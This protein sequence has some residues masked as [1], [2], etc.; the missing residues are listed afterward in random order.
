MIVEFRQSDS[1]SCGHCGNES[2]RPLGVPMV[3]GPCRVGPSFHDACRLEIMSDV[4]LTLTRP[5]M[6]HGPYG[7]VTWHMV[8]MI[9]HGID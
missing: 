6:V 3:K 4:R 9:W 8:S 2:R 1:A 5:F 7:F